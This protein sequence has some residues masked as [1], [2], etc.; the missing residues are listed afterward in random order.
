LD[1]AFE[2]RSPESDGDGLAV[3]PKSAGAAHGAL[4]SK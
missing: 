1:A 3:P 4:N 2:A